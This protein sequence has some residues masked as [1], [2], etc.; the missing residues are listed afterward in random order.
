M[1]FPFPIKS[2]INQMLFP[3]LQILRLERDQPGASQTTSNQRG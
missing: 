3:D 1:C 2:A